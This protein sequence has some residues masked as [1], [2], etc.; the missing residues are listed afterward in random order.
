VHI[1]DDRQQ[2]VS[3]HAPAAGTLFTVQNTHRDADTEPHMPM[4]M[5]MAIGAAVVLGMSTVLGLGL[6]AVLRA[7]GREVD[8][9]LESDLWTLAPTVRTNAPRAYGP[10]THA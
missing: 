8:E 9:L 1:T 10:K 5:W 2:V 3:A 7:V 4:L 6:A